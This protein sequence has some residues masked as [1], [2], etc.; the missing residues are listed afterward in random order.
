MNVCV[1]ALYTV[2]IN[3]NKASVQITDDIFNLIYL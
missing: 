1:A 3:K 2:K